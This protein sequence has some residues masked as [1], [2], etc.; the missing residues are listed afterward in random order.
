MARDLKALSRV[1]NEEEH[2]KAVALAV[3]PGG[4]LTPTVCCLLLSAARCLAA[5]S[6]STDLSLSL[7]PRSHTTR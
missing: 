2:P 7:R 1:F 6:R 4:R 3:K 5:S